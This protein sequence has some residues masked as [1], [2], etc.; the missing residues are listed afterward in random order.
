[1][2]IG[3]EFHETMSGSYRLAGSAERDRAMSFTIRAR[4]H[5]VL[6]F[7]RDRL[8]EIE[9]EVDLEGYADHRA[10]RGTLEID[11]L[12]GKKLVYAFAFE[13]NDGQKRR[14]VGKKSVELLH[15][16]ETM[17][18]LPGAILDD[19]GHTLGSAM[20]RFDARSDLVKWLRSFRS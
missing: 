2:A 13:D 11:P 17:T 19:G 6:R 10:M 4:V 16:L 14:F 1:M 12:L 7:L 3:F 5:S 8:A 9:G 15:L 20:L 18:T